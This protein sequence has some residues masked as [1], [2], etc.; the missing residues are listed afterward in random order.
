MKNEGNPSTVSLLC[1]GQCVQPPQT[2]A[3]SEGI[4]CPEPA[5]ALRNSGIDLQCQRFQAY[6]CCMQPA[7]RCILSAVVK[8]RI[9]AA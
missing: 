5:R 8:S 3:Y 9:R 2:A 1:S 4:V 6:V 7:G